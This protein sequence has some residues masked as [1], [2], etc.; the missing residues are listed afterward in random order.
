MAEFIKDIEFLVITNMDFELKQIKTSLPF[1]GFIESRQ[2]G[3]P[4]NQDSCGFTDT[5]LGLLV[6][7]CDGMGGGPGGKIASEVAVDTIVQTIRSATADSNREKAIDAAVQKAHLKLL[8]IQKEKPSLVGMGTTVTILLINK[9]SAMIAHVGDSRIYQLRRGGKIF[10]TEDH[11]LVG[12]MVRKKA[13]TEDEARMSSNLNIIQRALGVGTEVKADICER[14]YEKGD[15]FVL[16]TDGVWGA[17]KEKDL[18]ESLARTKVLSG[19]ME[20]TMVKVEELGGAEGNRHDN[21]TMALLTTNCNSKLKES[22]TT[23]VRNLLLGLSIV[24][25]LSLVG[26]V[27]QYVFHPNSTLDNIQENSSSVEKVAELEEQMREKDLRLDE[28]EK[29]IVSMKEKY[30]ETFDKLKKINTAKEVAKFVNENRTEEQE[31]KKQLIDRLDTLIIQLGKISDMMRGNDKNRQIAEVSKNIRNL[32][33]D[34]I[35]YGIRSQ[36]IENVVELLNNSI[37]KSD[38][39]DPNYNGK[40]QYKGHWT[41]T[42]PKGIITLVKDMKEQLK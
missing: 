41:G 13:I 24:C 37:A 23:K 16:C 4:E 7:V 18:M 39:K 38:K 12:E 28:M 19:A 32:S 15:R 33:H 10:R 42:N 25:G 11:S 36:Q 17:M 21:F 5:L 29:Q 3:R 31:V 30:D 1:L 14:A 35:P 6:V 27:V 2:G 26:N 9:Q 8:A 40:D 20:K 34:L 22:M